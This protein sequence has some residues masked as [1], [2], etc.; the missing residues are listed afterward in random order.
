MYRVELNREQVRQL[1][2]SWQNAGVDSI[3]KKLIEDLFLIT[4]TG[5]PPGIDRFDSKPAAG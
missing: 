4:E 2:D 5:S 3:E 1:L